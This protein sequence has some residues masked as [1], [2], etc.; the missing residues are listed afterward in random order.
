MEKVD[1]LLFWEFASRMS[2]KHPELPRLLSEY[3][4]R[5]VR[6]L[7]N[8]KSFDRDLIIGLLKIKT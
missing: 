3:G 7:K 8:L 2:P 5:S 1:D 4:R 6:D